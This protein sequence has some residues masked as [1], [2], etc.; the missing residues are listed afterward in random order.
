VA[1][2]LVV[3]PA[4]TTQGPIDNMLETFIENRGEGMGMEM[5]MGMGMQAGDIFLDLLLFLA[6]FASH[7]P[8]GPL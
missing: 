8:T 2:G 6:D 5:G 3:Y 1:P 4:H 7:T